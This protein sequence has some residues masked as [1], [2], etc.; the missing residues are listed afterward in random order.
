MGPFAQADG[1]DAPGLI[2]EAVPIVAA[3]ADDVVVVCNTRLESQLS[4]M[5][6]QTFSMTFSSGHFGGSG[7]GGML[8]GTATSPER[9]VTVR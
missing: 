4:R 6:C 8:R 1:H 7:S 5:N 9:C 3:V 2:D